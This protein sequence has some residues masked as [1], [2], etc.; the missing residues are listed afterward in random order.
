MCLLCGVYVCG[1]GRG[2]IIHMVIRGADF[3]SSGGALVRLPI[4]YR[5]GMLRHKRISVYA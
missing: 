4:A 1:E 3:L 5:G 2:V